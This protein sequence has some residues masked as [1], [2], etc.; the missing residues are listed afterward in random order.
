MGGPAKSQLI[1]EV[2]ALGG[3]IGV[4]TDLTF[5]QMKMLNT[6]KGPAVQALRA[7]SDRLQ[8]HSR[9]KQT[10]DKEKGNMQRNWA[11]R[12]KQIE[13]LRNNTLTIHGS[14][15]GLIEEPLPEIKS[16]E[17]EEAEIIVENIET[18]ILS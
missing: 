14:F 13:N 11:E 6:N 4:S 9:M 7:Q 1:R 5:L 12:E 8:Y 2:D 17:F 16:L 3:Q 15:S 10:L 18:K